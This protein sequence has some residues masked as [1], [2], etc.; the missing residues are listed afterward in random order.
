MHN[1]L[2]ILI[3]LKKKNKIFKIIFINNFIILFIKFYF[4][5]LASFFA[6]LIIIII[7]KLLNVF[8]II[9]L[10]FSIIDLQFSDVCIDNIQEYF[11]VIEIFYCTILHSDYLNCEKQI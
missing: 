8:E 5:S 3:F 1:I 10:I 2:F 6:D 7:I 4:D 11:I 9:K